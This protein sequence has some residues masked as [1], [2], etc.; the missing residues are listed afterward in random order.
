AAREA[1]E[2][3]WEA[4]QEASLQWDQASKDVK[5]ERG[6]LHPE[7]AARAADAAAAD[8]RTADATWERKCAEGF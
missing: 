8:A 7:V 4:A 1:A 3:R 6:D 2:A 5:A